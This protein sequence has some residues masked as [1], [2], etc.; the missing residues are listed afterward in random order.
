MVKQSR[1]IFKVIFRP[2]ATM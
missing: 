1:V 2:T